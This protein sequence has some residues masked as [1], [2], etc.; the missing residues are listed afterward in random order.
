ML[1]SWP[2]DDIKAVV[3]TD[4]EHTLG[5][6]DLG[7][8]VM[9]IQVGKLVLYT[10]CR[11]VNSQQCLPVM[12]DVGTNNQELLGDTLY[13]SLQ[14]E[15]M[16]GEDY[17]QLLEEFMQAVTHKGATQA[18][19]M[20][21][22]MH[23]LVQFEDFTNVN[24]FCLLNKYQDKY[25]MFSDDIQGTD[26]IA[27]AGILVTLW[28]TRSQLSS[29]V[30]IFQRAGE[31]A[32][33]ITHLLVMAPEKEGI[34]AAEATKKIWMVDS[35]RLTVKMYCHLSP[36]KETFAQDHAEKGSLE[37]V[38]QQVKPTTIIGVAVMAGAFTE[39]LLRDTASFHERPI[40]FALS[41]PTSRAE[42]TAEQ[43]YHATQGWGIFSSSSPF[44]CMTLE[45][46]H[47]LMPGQGNNAYVF[48]GLALGVIAGDVWN[49]PDELF[50]LT[51]EVEISQEVSEQHLLQGRLYP[52]LSSIRDVDV[53]LR[54]AIKVL[55]YAYKHNLDTYYPEPLD[56]E[57]FVCSLV[58]T[59]DYDSFS[60]DSYKWPKEAMSGQMV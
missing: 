45:D 36:E 54:I 4:G 6:G 40:I 8:Y 44:E 52:P 55:T 41:N 21:Y 20:G 26:S 53:S 22:G 12:L 47:T 9:G 27:V 39:Q 7:C 57:V 28:V 51:A 14:Q 19:G 43:C 15:S 25:C 48:P 13:I 34:P 11:R 2:E 60:L 33:G 50:L 59:P 42:C 31:A 17:D 24:A 10:V 32:L 30:F 58:Y 29:H 38:V 18:T 1:N 3:V 46:G 5:L 35:R 49:I 56:K 16:H 37:E 23:C